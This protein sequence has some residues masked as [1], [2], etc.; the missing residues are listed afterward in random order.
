MISAA[1]GEG[2]DELLE[3]VGAMLTGDMVE[4]D[5][6]WMNGE[7]LTDLS[8]ERLPTLADKLCRIARTKSL[9]TETDSPFAILAKENDIMWSGGELS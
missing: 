3:K 8:S 5:Q 4:R 1:T 2:L 6:R 7:S 9:D